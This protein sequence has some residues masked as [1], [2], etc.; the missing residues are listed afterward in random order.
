MWQYLF[1]LFKNILT[2]YLMGNSLSRGPSTCT[3][4][5]NQ[6][7]STRLSIFRTRVT[8]E[9]ECVPH[10]KYQRRL[11]SVE[12]SGNDLLICGNTT[13]PAS[14][15]TTTKPTLSSPAL[16]NSQK[17]N[18]SCHG[19]RLVCNLPVGTSRNELQDPMVN[20]CV[21]KHNQ[22]HCGVNVKMIRDYIWDLVVVFGYFLWFLSAC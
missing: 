9:D 7:L 19:S 17:N 1:I 12:P 5:T 20:S 11:N 22:W 2:G 21:A 15:V 3:M 10:Y 6:C 16:L 18:S 8:V 4:L 13:R 14:L